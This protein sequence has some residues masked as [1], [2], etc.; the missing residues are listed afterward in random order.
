MAEHRNERNRNA[1]ELQDV[2]LPGV[3]RSVDGALQGEGGDR[4]LNFGAIRTHNL[5]LQNGQ[6]VRAGCG[7]CGEDLEGVLEDVEE[8]G[9]RTDPV[10]QGGGIDE[11][12]ST[13]PTHSD[14]P[15]PWR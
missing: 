4:M 6:R 14:E 1:D 2:E 15:S 10:V 5:H 8:S 12:R 13:T 3:P 11:E 7:G 9:K